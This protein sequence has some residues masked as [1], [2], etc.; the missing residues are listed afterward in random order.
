MSQERWTDADEAALRNLTE[1]KE[2][3]NRVHGERL[4]KVAR[5]I[6]NASGVMDAPD[7][8]HARDLAEALKRN[9]AS[10]RDALAP[11]DSGVRCAIAD[12]PPDPV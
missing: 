7:G 5:Q 4:L 9:A 1:R 8:R 6:L 12:E 3:V 11:F 2:R 10:A